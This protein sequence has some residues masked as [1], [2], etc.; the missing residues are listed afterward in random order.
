VSKSQSRVL[1]VDDDPA[2]A[3][4]LTLALGLQGYDVDC[5]GDGAEAIAQLRLGSYAAV[6]LDLGLPRVDGFGVCRW[7]RGR[8]DD[9]PVLMLTARHAVA[10]RVRGLDV[11]AD[12]YLVKP[13]ALA[14]LQARLRAL[15]RRAADDEDDQRLAYADLELDLQTLRARRGGRPIH[16]TPTEQRLLELFLTHPEQVLLRDTLYERV[17]GADLSMSSKALD[18]YIGYLR[19]KTEA[20]GAP[21]LIQTARGLGFLLAR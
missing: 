7:L 6:I 20:G 3:R 1:V 13:F 8:R 4:T 14:E 5:A 11:G 19:R 15:L 10:D 17:W 12:D 9:T 2:L 21:R 16:L 18:V